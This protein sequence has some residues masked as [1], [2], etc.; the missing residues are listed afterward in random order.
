MKAFAVGRSF[1]RCSAFCA[2]FCYLIGFASCMSCLSPIRAVGTL[3]IEWQHACDS[4]SEKQQTASSRF[5]FRQIQCI[6]RSYMLVYVIILLKRQIKQ[7]V[8]KMLVCYEYLILW[9]HFAL[10]NRLEHEFP[11]NE[12]VSLGY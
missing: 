10:S 8:Y 7:P 4:R 3:P 2:L 11:R 9:L 1:V 5:R 12:R 6:S